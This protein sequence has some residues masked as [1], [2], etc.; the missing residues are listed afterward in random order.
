MI[1]NRESGGHLLW[2]GPL[3]GHLIVASSGM[4]VGARCSLHRL[5]KALKAEA[6]FDTPNG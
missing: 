5:L 3:Y 2:H 1:F 4:R 6:F